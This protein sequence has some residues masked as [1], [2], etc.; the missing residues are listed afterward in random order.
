MFPPT[1]HSDDLD[2]RGV[3]ANAQARDYQKFNLGGGLVLGLVVLVISTGCER[4]LRIKIDEKNPPTFTL[5][6]SGNLVYLYRSEVHDH[7]RPLY[8]DPEMWKIRPTGNDKIFKLPPITYGTIPNGFIQVAPVSGAPPLGCLPEARGGAERQGSARNPKPDLRTLTH[9]Q[10]RLSSQ[11]EPIC[12]T[13]A[14]CQDFFNHSHRVLDEFPGYGVVLCFF[15]ADLCE[16]GFVQVEY[17]R[18]GIRHQNR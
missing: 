7:K 11:P 5:S 10:H 3:E 2:F 4:D 14:L 15:I 13:L 17:L 8:G 12:S 9:L 16:S 1:G 18:S 6:G